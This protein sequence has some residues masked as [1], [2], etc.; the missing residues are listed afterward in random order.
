MG[1]RIINFLELRHSHGILHGGLPTRNERYE[2]RNPIHFRKR[3]IA[4]TGYVAQRS[5]RS[6]GAKR[7]D[8]G[9]FV[10]SIFVRAILKHFSATVIAEVKVDIWHRDTAGVKK[11]LK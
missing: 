2:L 3:N 11:T 7:D 1:L 9:N 10:I 6:H 5:F 4:H 8:L